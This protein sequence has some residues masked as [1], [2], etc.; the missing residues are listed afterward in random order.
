MLLIQFGTELIVPHEIGNNLVARKQTEHPFS[1]DS[2][3]SK[4]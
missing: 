3:Y 4:K 1:Y 2:D